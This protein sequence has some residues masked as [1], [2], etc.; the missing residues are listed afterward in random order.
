MTTFWITLILVVIILVFRL[1]NKGKKSCGP[2]CQL[3]KVSTQ[4]KIKSYSD[5]QKEKEE[6]K[7]TYEVR[8]REIERDDTKGRLGFFEDYGKKKEKK[9]DK[10]GK[11]K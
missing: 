11:K 2:K 6:A 8:L 5:Q 1:M 4:K 9:K 10:K 7:K 3:P